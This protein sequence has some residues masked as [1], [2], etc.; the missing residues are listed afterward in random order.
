MRRRDLFLLGVT[1]GL[2][3]ALRPAQAQGL[4]HKYVMRGQ[5]RPDVWRTQLS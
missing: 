2:A 1:A 5:L 4:W 3:P